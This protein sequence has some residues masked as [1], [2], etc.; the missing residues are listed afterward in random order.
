MQTLEEVSDQSE[1][2]GPM[3]DQSESIG[4][5]ADQSKPIDPMRFVMGPKHEALFDEFNALLKKIPPLLNRLTM[6]SKL[7]MWKNF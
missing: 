1:S 5:M 3:V 7:K 4:P 2:I 6:S